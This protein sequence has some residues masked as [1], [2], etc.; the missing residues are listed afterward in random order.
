[1]SVERAA[2]NMHFLTSGL[3]SF[4]ASGTK[5]WKRGF[6]CEL[7]RCCESLLRAKAMPHLGR[8]WICELTGFSQNLLEVTITFATSNALQKLRKNHYETKEHQVSNLC[9]FPYITLRCKFPKGQQPFSHIM[10]FIPIKHYRYIG[11]QRQ[12]L[13]SLCL[14]LENSSSATRYI[15]TNEEISLRQAVNK[16]IRN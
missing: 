8:R 15:S 10:T 14:L 7:S 16:T 6:T 12:T 4:R 9:A 3:R 1:M 5:N 2:S 13:A 11:Q